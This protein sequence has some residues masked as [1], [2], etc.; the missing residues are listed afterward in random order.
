MIDNTQPYLISNEYNMTEL[1]AHF[2]S[3][4]II[5]TMRDKIKN[6][7]YYS[8]IKEPNIIDSFEKNFKIMKE[9]FPG[10]ESNIN[11]VRTRVYIEI[12]NTLCEAFNLAHNIDL[13]YN[14]SN[15]NTAA[16]Y[17]YDFLVCSRNIIMINFFTSFIINN[18]DSLYSALN[19]DAYKKNKDVSALY[20]KRIYD[21]SKYAIIS[22]NIE[23][24][25]EYISTLDISLLNIFQST[26]VNPQVVSFLDETFADR[27][28]FFRDYYCSI[29]NNKETLP[30]VITDI[31]LQLQKI[32]GNG[33]II[34]YLKG[35][36][37]NGK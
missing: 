30:I 18:K 34:N 22:T 8:S 33:N 28:N 10:D 11:L 32:I 14:Q 31:R 16:Y 1:L 26:Y 6:I 15:I 17:A 21:D 25:I 35:D 2:D 19:L 24:I 37:E 23:K 12:L 9:K 3:D 7:N 29:V 27:G 4:Y 20:N 13:E 36:S 5:S